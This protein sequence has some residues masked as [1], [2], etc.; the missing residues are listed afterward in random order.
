MLTPSQRFLKRARSDASRKS[1]WKTKF[2]DSKNSNF[3]N[4]LYSSKTI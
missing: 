3:G 2:Q 4:K 1:G